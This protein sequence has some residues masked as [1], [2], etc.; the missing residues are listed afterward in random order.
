[1][2]D[3]AGS[4]PGSDAPVEDKLIFLQANMV[5]FASQ[6]N[7]PVIEVSLVVS[8][9]LRILTQSL[10]EHAKLHRETIPEDLLLS[11]PLEAIPITP[12][13]SDFPIETL[14]DKVDQDRMD[15]LDTILRTTI[16]KT[17]LPFPHAI[18]L[19]RDWEG[20]VRAQLSQATSPGHLFSPVELPDG[21]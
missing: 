18:S 8:K 3:E 6:Y 7:L 15:I 1:M 5:S 9:Y 21:F 17:E 14:L 11:R 10:E 2:V 13:L 12:N 16:N 20:I 4:I 19:L